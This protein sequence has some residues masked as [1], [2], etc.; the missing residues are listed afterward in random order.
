MSANLT[1]L[2]KALE[3]L[4]EMGFILEAG[5]EPLPDFDSV[6]LKGILRARSRC[7]S[8]AGGCP[9][10]PVYSGGGA[11]VSAVLEKSAQFVMEG[12]PVESDRCNLVKSKETANRP[13]DRLFFELHKETIDE[14]LAKHGRRS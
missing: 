11:E 7:P 3:S 4:V 1:N 8:R 6:L 2:G 5:G 13:K 10:R 12:V 9:N 14:L